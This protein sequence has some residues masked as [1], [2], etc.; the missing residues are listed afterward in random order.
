MQ[1]G[2]GEQIARVWASIPIL[3]AELSSYPVGAVDVLYRES[4]ARFEADAA[5][6]RFAAINIELGPEKLPMRCGVVGDNVLASGVSQG[7]R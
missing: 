1:V 7:S 4:L 5:V 3:A 6:K 2:F